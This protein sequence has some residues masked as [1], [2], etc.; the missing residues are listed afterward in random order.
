MNARYLDPLTDI[1]R[2]PAVVALPKAD[3]HLHQEWSPRLNRVL[4]RR[5][6]RPSYDWRDWM[7]RLMAETPPGMPRLERL[8]NVFPASVEDDADP[9]NFIARIEDLLEEGAR[10]G[11]LLV[12]MR[13]GGETAVQHPDFMALFRE[14]ER[15][16]RIHY[17]TLCAEA[18]Y[19]LLLWYE[20]DRLERVLAACLC[21][22]REGL[23]GVDLLYA[24][25][26]TEADWLHNYRVAGRMADGGLGVTAHVGEFATANIA[27]ALRTPGLTRLGHAVYAARDPRLLDAVAASGVTVECSLGSNVVLGAAPS[28][29]EHPIRRFMERGVPVALCTDDPVQLGTTIGREYA[30]AHALGF[31]PDE[32]LGVTA[33]AIRAA[34]LTPE[35]RSALLDRTRGSGSRSSTP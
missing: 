16:V 3:I 7:R 30:L 1:P 10:D 26:D 29:A 19:S 35:R 32:L 14:A 4:S 28:Y 33:N 24:P 27:A 31:T 6:G 15:R 12:E 22:A 13:F 25:Y 17:P 34:F 2:D 23:A 5:A 11:A 8:A 18:L 21:A 9:E 20:D